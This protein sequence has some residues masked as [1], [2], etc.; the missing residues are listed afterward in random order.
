[1]S[2][3]LFEQYLK[4]AKFNQAAQSDTFVEDYARIKRM[5]ENGSRKVED[6]R[7]FHYAIEPQ[8][9]SNVAPSTTVF[10]SFPMIVDTGTTFV[11]QTGA[12]TVDTS[13]AFYG[14]FNYYF[15]PPISGSTVTPWV[16]NL[17]MM[18]PNNTNNTP[19]RVPVLGFDSSLNV[20][21]PQTFNA[22]NVVMY[23]AWTQFD[24][25]NQGE[26][27]DYLFH[28]IRVRNSTGALGSL[29]IYFHFVFTGYQITLF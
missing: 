11:N 17:E 2:E 26:V 10:H 29:E 14:H 7:P 9:L 6:I 24:K 12:A 22:N 5:I 19:N 23:N 3:K 18:T 1:M 28:N 21:T 13:R 20:Y 4:E 15:S 16:M 8:L 27:K 25:G